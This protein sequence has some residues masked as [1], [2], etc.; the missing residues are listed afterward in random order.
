MNIYTIGFSGKTAEEFFTTLRK[1]NVKKLIDIRLNNK[2]QLAGFT[3]IKHLPYFL[4]LHNIE[5][6]YLP[7]FAPTK[8]LLYSYDKKK[9]DWEDYE[10]IFLQILEK[11]KILEKVKI[12]DF[13][14]AVLLCSEPTAEKCHRRLT[15]EY[16]KENF[17]EKEIKIIHL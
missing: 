17:P 16:L 13:D 10:K 14:N 1:H 2:S 4:K 11:R 5:Y 8:E 3:N 6:M 12:E 7:I 9:I 15:A